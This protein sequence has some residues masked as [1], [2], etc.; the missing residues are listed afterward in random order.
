MKKRI[1][2]SLAGLIAV[3]LAVVLTQP[4]AVDP[5]ISAATAPQAEAGAA[6]AA[7]TTAEKPASSAASSAGMPGRSETDEPAGP[8]A[9]LALTLPSAPQ[10]K[11]PVPAGSLRLD[12]LARTRDLG[13]QGDA[14]G[15]KSWVIIPPPPPPAPFVVEAP[16]APPLP[17]RYMGQVNDGR[18]LLTYFL[19]RGTETLAVSVG[20]SID[21]SYR[22]ERA[23]GGVLHFLYLP[24]QVQQSLQIGVGP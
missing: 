15:A 2:W 19:L 12:L 8:P 10:S 3:L 9:D 18:G 17:F 7:Q 22:L 21:K 13:H 11:A 5:T 23:E 16:R 4:E 1:F 24:L 6:G 14:F 20:E